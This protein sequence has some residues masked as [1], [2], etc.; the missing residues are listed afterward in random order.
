MWIAANV[1]LRGDVKLGESAMRRFLP[2]RFTATA[3][4]IDSAGSTATETACPRCH[5]PVPRVLL[6]CPT[7]FF[8]ILGA[9]ASGKSYLL[10]SMVWQARRILPELFQLRFTDAD[11]AG[12][13]RLN[14]YEEQ[15]FLAEDPDRLVWPTKTEEQGDLYDRADALESTVDMTK[16]QLQRQIEFQ[17]QFQMELAR[18]IDAAN[19]QLSGA[20]SRLAEIQNTDEEA[21]RQAVSKQQELLRQV[22]DYQG[23]LDKLSETTSPLYND[24]LSDGRDL[25]IIRFGDHP[26]TSARISVRNGSIRVTSS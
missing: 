1:N 2:T 12:N 10:T 17:K 26:Q 4:A 18:Q 20:T 25:V 14:E 22:A 23:L 13:G 21:R 8:S 6:E 11:A 7:L 15:Q 16:E 9:P 19:K 24:S 3:E 5:L